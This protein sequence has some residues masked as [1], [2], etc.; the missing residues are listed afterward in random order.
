MRNECFTMLG[1]IY[2][3][4]L[5][6]NIGNINRTEIK[7]NLKLLSIKIGQMTAR[8]VG[9][10]ISSCDRILPKQNERKEGKS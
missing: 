4:A 3:K 6:V 7:P 2:Q 10:S 9:K 8:I 1:I 5:F